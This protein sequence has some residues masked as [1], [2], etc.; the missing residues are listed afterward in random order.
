MPKFQSLQRLLTFYLMTLVMMLAL[1]YAMMVV[2]IKNINQEQSLQALEAFKFEIFSL[3]TPNDDD[4]AQILKKPVFQELS[5]QLIFMLPSGQTY[6]HRATRP[7]EQKFAAVTFP[8]LSHQHHDEHSAYTLSEQTLTATLDLNNKAQVY[9]VIRHKPVQIEWTAYP[10][11][12]PLMVAIALFIGALL[13]IL[14]RRNNWEQLLDY[15]NNLTLTAKDGY[16]PPPFDKADSPIEFLRLGHLLGRVSHD[17]RQKQRQIKLLSHRLERLV[18]KAPLPTLMIT[19]QGQISFFNQRFEQ[20]FTTQFQRETSYKLTDFVTGS[21][22]PTQQLL[23][24]LDNQKVARSLLVFG[25]DDKLAYQL[26]LTPWFGDNGQIH[27]FTVMLNNIDPWL[28]KTKALET[29]VELQQQSIKEMTRLRSMIGHE[30]RTPLNAIIGT[31]DLIDAERLTADQQDLLKTLLQSSQS[32]LTL[33][34]DMLEMAKIESGAAVIIDEPVDIFKVSQHVSTLMIGA[35]RQKGLELIYAFMPD[36]PRYIHTDHTRLRQILLNLLD[37]SIKFTTTGHVA[38]VID[39]I[40]SE[41]LQRITDDKLQE[42]LNK[43][44]TALGVQTV[45]DRDLTTHR[46]LEEMA[47]KQQSWIRFRVMDTGI[48]ISFEEQ[49]RLFTYFNQAN[50]QISR[51]FGGSGLGLAISSS[52]AKLLGGFILL[53]SEKDHGSCFDLFLPSQTPKFRPLYLSNHKFSHLQ[54]IGIINNRLRESYLQRLG[55]H[56]SLPTQLYHKIDHQVLQDI[57]RTLS[58]LPSAKSPVLLIDYEYY[59][60]VQDSP[61]QPLLKQLI[62]QKSVAKILMSM[63]AERGIPSA[64][65]EQFDGFLNKPIDVARLLSELTRLTQAFP[66]LTPDSPEP[67][68]NDAINFES[69]APSPQDNAQP[70]ADATAPPPLILIVEDN[71]TNQKITK[72]MLEKLGYRSLLAEDGQQ[73]LEVLADHRQDIALILMD[74]RMPVMD[75]LEATKAI[76]AMGDDIIIIALTANNSDEDKA[77]CLAV[78][79]N[80]FLAKPVNKAQL[81]TVLEKLLPSQN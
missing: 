48:G 23:Q 32:M 72:K 78:G 73:A 71:I 27:G 38:L 52:F 1:Y 28:Q 30:L 40:S 79:M 50:N 76:R 59:V 44:N 49:Q 51:Q 7:D 66:E 80:E 20:A 8:V 60:S 77:A 47:Q 81:Q 70:K 14:K 54:L 26:H 74:Y 34:N 25:L 61:A 53:T 9:L 46:W 31:L 17:L 2:L 18:D 67:Q 63:K 4:I 3:V 15:A 69:K 24:R 62:A 41:E 12:L 68:S 19:R 56:L 16:T 35:A 29:E 45:S 65:L 13:F 75:G 33:L 37:N 58:Q 36:C 39:L 10:S 22:K 5:Y 64:L 42:K 43:L 55:E 21:D 6:V 57:D 11:W